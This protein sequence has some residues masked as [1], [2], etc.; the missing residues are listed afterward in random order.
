MRNKT[1]LTIPLAN[2]EHQTHTHRYSPNRRAPI[3]G[4]RFQH[5][6]ENRRYVETLFA[7]VNNAPTGNDR[8]TRQSAVFRPMG[9]MR[10]ANSTFAMLAKTG[11]RGAR[12][13][14]VGEGG[15]QCV[16]DAATCALCEYAARD[17][18]PLTTG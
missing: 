5:D 3:C 10:D 2:H 15:V 7:S 12:R 11:V 13:R 18:T 1:S 4:K 14:G 17:A 8:E 16:S 6:A 9:P